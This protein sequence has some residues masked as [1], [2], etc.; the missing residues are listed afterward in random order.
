MPG[1]SLPRKPAA[2]LY[3]DVAG[4]SR[5][6]G[7]DDGYF[8]DGLTEESINALA[9]LAE[10]LIAARSS[11]FH[12]KDRNVPVP[13]IGEQFAVNYVVVGAVR[14]S[15]DRVRIA[16]QL[17]R[18]EDGFELWS[19]TYWTRSRAQSRRALSRSRDPLAA[20]I[21][22]SV[23]GKA[24]VTKYAYAPQP[25]PIFRRAPPVHDVG[26][27]P[28]DASHS[29]NSGILRRRNMTSERPRC[30]SASSFDPSQEL[31]ESF[32]F[33]RER[34]SAGDQRT[35]P[36]IRPPNFGIAQ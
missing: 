36:S 12:F 3:A 17:V 11:S 21:P 4:Y 10:P 35:A 30:E 34:L 1:H 31:R 6:T 19:E 24:V 15:D 22:D 7:E 14:R 32:L 29:S 20:A 23:T 18:S 8:A 25:A 26:A 9:T 13:E 33:G 5:P 16:A 28:H 2:I 27:T